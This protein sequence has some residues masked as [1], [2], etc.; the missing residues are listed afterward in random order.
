[1]S[2]DLY[3]FDCDVPDDEE[4]IGTWLEDDARW[5]AP[6]TP[7]L[8]EFVAHLEAR[9]PGLADEPDASP[10]ASW[11][12]TQS[13]VDGQ[14]CGFNIVWSQADQ[15]SDEMRTLCRERSLTLYDP[16]ES[17]VLRP[18]TP[19]PTL[20]RSAAGGNAVSASRGRRRRRR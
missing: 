3:V 8:A 20:P 11:P 10:W 18:E 19:D 5:D 13:M 2:F 17:L 6:L 15:L 16:Q 14:C 9:F 1:M 4:V 7:R 12:L